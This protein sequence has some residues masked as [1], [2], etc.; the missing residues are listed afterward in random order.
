MK[1]KLWRVQNYD[2]KKSESLSKSLGVSKI[3]SNL[4]VQRGIDSF[5][6]SKNFLGQV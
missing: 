2:K 6:K 1:E 4:L 3:I 5:N